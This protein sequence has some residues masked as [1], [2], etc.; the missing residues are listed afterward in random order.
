[1]AGVSSVIAARR[2]AKRKAKAKAVQAKVMAKFSA[3]QKSFASTRD[4]DDNGDSDGDAAPGAAENADAEMD[5]ANDDDWLPIDT[6]TC[7]QCQKEIDCARTGRDDPPACLL[8]LVQES[9]GAREHAPGFPAVTTTSSCGHGMHLTCFRQWQ[10]T[11]VREI[12]AFPIIAS[13]RLEA[14]VGGQRTC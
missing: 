13:E 6:I 4:V 5:D 1:M 2:A 14:A 9:V 7:L 11:R 8:A 3:M 12:M 10:Q